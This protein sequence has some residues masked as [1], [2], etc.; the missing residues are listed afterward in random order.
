MFERAKAHR[1]AHITDAHNYEEFCDAVENE[2]TG[3]L[4][5]SILKTVIFSMSA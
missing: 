1:D 4:G 3:I 5:Q 2:K